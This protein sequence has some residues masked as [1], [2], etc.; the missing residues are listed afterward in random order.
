MSQL[1]AGKLFLTS[2]HFPCQ[3]STSAAICW[4]P[5]QLQGDFWC[6]TRFVNDF[7]KGQ[8]AVTHQLVWECSFCFLVTDLWPCVTKALRFMCCMCQTM[9]LSEAVTSHSSLCV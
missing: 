9:S 5:T 1:V 4:L 8:P 6:D 7:T 3:E 2:Q